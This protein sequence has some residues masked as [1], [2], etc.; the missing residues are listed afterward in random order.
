[1]SSV[2]DD[3]KYGIVIG[4]AVVVLALIGYVSWESPRSSSAS[5]LA[6]EDAPGAPDDT[7][8]RSEA[9]DAADPAVQP[10][11]TAK[12][13]PAADIP[14]EHPE[15]RPEPVAAASAD[16]ASAEASAPAA[17][18]VARLPIGFSVG[19]ASPS[20]PR[21]DR[22]ARVIKPFQSCTGRIVLTGHSDVTGDP[23][24]N[25]TLSRQRAQAAR[26]VVH[27]YL[28]DNAHIEVRGAGSADPETLDNTPQAR[29]MNRRV[30]ITC[31]ADS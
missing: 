25:M 27:G 5:V 22:L 6:D 18:T 1:M 29:R 10:P 11:P 31:D 20:R 28:G 3:R 24:E 13:S 17:P 7:P 21:A 19:S 12:T 8:V 23:R 4:S 14:K 16:E 15:E 26:E 2:H 9:S 30:T